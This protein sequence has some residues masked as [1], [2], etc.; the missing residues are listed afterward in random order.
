MRTTRQS[1]TR[2]EGDDMTMQQVMEMKHGLQEAMA[3]SKAEAYTS[4]P[5]GVASEE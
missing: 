2:A 5:R 4:G 1:S 3:S